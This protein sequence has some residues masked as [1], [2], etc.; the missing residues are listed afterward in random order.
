MIHNAKNLSEYNLFVDKKNIYFQKAIFKSTKSIE[1]SVNKNIEPSFLELFSFAYDGEFFPVKETKFTVRQ[2]DKKIY[3]SGD[4]NIDKNYMVKYDSDELN[5]ILDPAPGKI[6]DTEF[7]ISEEKN[8]GLSI[9]DRYLNFKLWSPPAIR[10]EIIFYDKDFK[11]IF[12]QKKFIAKRK[13]KGVFECSVLKKDID[14]S[15]K[16]QIYYRYRIFA[17]GKTTEAIDP[18]SKALGI[19]DSRTEEIGFSAIIDST[20]NNEKSSFLN[21][22]I[23]KSE[24]DCV[25][26]EAS[27]RDFTSEPRTVSPQEAGTFKGFEQKIPYLK[28]LGITHLQFMPV[29]K[30]YTLVDTDKEFSDKNTQNYNYNWGYDPLNYF[31]LENKYSSEAHNPVKAIN[32]YKQL[33]EKLHEQE[34]GVIQ[35]VVFN[36]TH[37]VETFENIAPGCYHR[38]K[39]DGTISGHTGAGPSIESRH[40]SVRKFIVDVLK[41]FVDE[42]NVDGFRFDLMSFTDHKTMAEIREKVGKQY[43]PSNFNDLILHGEAWNFTD[44]DDNSQYTKDKLP[45]QDLNIAVFNDSFRDSI[46]GNGHY[47]GII[48]GNTTQASRMAT[49][50]IGA[51][52]YYDSE[53][54]PFQEEIFFDKY[55]LFARKSSECLNYI[56]IHDGLTFWDK[57]NIT[58]N[59]E[60]KDYR[61]KLSKTAAALL[62]LSAGKVILNSGDEILRTKPLANYDIEK[63]RAFT[64]H[65]TNT[66]E[67]TVLFHENSYQSPD[68]TNM[69][70]WSRL[71]NQYSTQA[72]E[73]LSFYKNIIKIR[74]KFYYLWDISAK[75]AENFKFITNENDNI[76]FDKNKIHSFFNNKLA[77][78]TINFS[79]GPAN[80]RYFIAGEIH[81]LNPNPYD[82]KYILDFDQHGNAKITFRRKEIQD[83]DN[84]KWSSSNEINIKL[85]KTPGEWDY[86]EFAYSPEGNNTIYPSSINENFEVS[87]NLAVRD[88]KTEQYKNPMAEKY[89]AYTIQKPNEN[90][91]TVIYNFSSEK[92]KFK[93]KI[94]KNIKPHDVLINSELD[95]NNEIIIQENTIIVNSQTIIAIETKF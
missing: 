8:F 21:S 61:L 29:N 63:Q 38:V 37:T 54:L 42:F 53:I 9:N 83:F 10:A 91:I 46:A 36:H 49:G 95:K 79:S 11:Q 7:D 57:L 31:A 18:Y 30:S 90:G 75:N 78:L 23:M 41:Y 25:F 55:N 48:Q 85:V 65:E 82:N 94:L 26:Y 1:I 64:S 16:T 87:I 60:S 13:K 92:I 43:N 19:F 34:I 73:L 67:D 74:R 2:S 17:Y 47:K 14:F 70:R 81:K 35:D 72:N 50:I 93:N 86:P 27:I 3:L 77:R 69:I 58:I 88:Y 76:I 52:Q 5:V 71:T 68:Y 33:I 89:I 4:F 56:S 66:E 40:K 80:K 32:E 44:I 24:L 39:P 84:Y 45:K 22:K 6:L 28:Q 51:L 12:A 15:E 62:F 20:Q 59:D